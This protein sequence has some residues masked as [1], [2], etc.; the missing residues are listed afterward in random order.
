MDSKFRDWSAS[1]KAGC[2]SVPGKAAE[3]GPGTW[4]SAARVQFLAYIHPGM[5]IHFTAI[6]MRESLD[7]KKKSK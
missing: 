5:D 3:G 6:F 1:S 7:E 2:S 4:D